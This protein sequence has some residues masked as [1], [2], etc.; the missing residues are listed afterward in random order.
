MR[1]AASWM[2]AKGGPTAPASGSIALKPT[3]RTGFMPDGA[4]AEP[5]GRVVCAKTTDV[6]MRAASAA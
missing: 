4:D 1:A 6:M 2:A 3:P 5:A